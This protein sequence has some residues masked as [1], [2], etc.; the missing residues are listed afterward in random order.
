MST[1]GL[2][3]GNLVNLEQVWE[4]KGLPKARG[5][6]RGHHRRRSRGT[7]ISVAELPR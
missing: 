4:L 6:R 1:R 2:F 7:R 5:G 3:Y